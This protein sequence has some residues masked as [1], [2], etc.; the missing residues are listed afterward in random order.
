MR[1]STSLVNQKK[2]I[3]S[4]DLRETSLCCNLSPRGLMF[5]RQSKELTE[6]LSLYEKKIFKTCITIYFFRDDFTH[7][8]G[9]GRLPAHPSLPE[10]DQGPGS[11]RAWLTAGAENIVADRSH[12]GKET[13]LTSYS[14]PPGDSFAS[15]FSLL[16]STEL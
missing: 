3:I 6:Q 15:V 16:A 1:C 5:F 9:A 10:P 8:Q 13:F 2:Q 12:P 11:P 7:S 14:G 4:Y